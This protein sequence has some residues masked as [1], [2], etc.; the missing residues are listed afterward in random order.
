LPNAVSYITESVSTIA[1]YNDQEELF[2]NYPVAETA[3]E[4]GFKQKTS[5]SVNDLPFEPKIAEAY[6]RLFHSNRLREYSFDNQ[7]V[8]LTRVKK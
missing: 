6:L 2:L 8:I 5:I 7:R 3:I 4:E 1:R